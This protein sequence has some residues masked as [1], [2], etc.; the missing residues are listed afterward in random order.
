MLSLFIAIHTM[1][2]I[3]WRNVICYIV[4]WIFHVSDFLRFFMMAFKYG[5]VLL[6]YFSTARDFYH[7]YFYIQYN[8]YSKN[9]Y[10]VL[11]VYCNFLLFMLKKI[12][13]ISILSLITLIPFSSLKR[14]LISLIMFSSSN[15]AFPIITWKK[16]VF[17]KK[18]KFYY[19]PQKNI[20]K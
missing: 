8:C 13:N 16:L 1:E 4:N 14:F 19:T 18:V 7:H 17:L 6:R 5:L 11:L 3:C 12:L 15:I 2:E 20:Q 10:L 9:C